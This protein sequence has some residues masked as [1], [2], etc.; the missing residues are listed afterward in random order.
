MSKPPEATRHP[1]FKKILILLSLRGIQFRPLHFDTPCIISNK[2]KASWQ[3]F[4][5]NGY[6]QQYNH[7]NTLPIGVSLIFEFQLL[8]T[9]LSDLWIPPSCH[10]VSIFHTYFESHC[11][12]LLNVIISLL[13]LWTPLSRHRNGNKLHSVILPYLFSIALQI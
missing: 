12:I 13:D 5:T 10:T 4:K 8:H 11:K 2:T 9:S 7:S 6:K 3:K 1:S